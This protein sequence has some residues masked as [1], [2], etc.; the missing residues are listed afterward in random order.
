[1]E[2]LMYRSS[3]IVPV[4]CHLFCTEPAAQSTGN[5]SMEPDTETTGDLTILRDKTSDRLAVDQDQPSENTLVTVIRVLYTCF[6]VLSLILL[7]SPRTQVINGVSLDATVNIT[8]VGNPYTVNPVERDVP[9]Q[10]PSNSRRTKRSAARHALGVRRAAAAVR[11]GGSR[12][13]VLAVP[14]LF[15]RPMNTQRVVSPLLVLGI[16][17]CHPF[18]VEFPDDAQWVR[19]IQQPAVMDAA[20]TASRVGNGRDVA[21]K[22]LAGLKAFAVSLAE[23]VRPESTEHATTGGLASGLAVGGSNGV[24]EKS[25]NETVQRGAE[26][27]A[28]VPRG[29]CPF[30]VKIFNAETAGFAGIIIHNKAT[31]E[32]ADVPVRMSPNKLGAEVTD[33]RAMFVTQRDGN[34][35]LAEAIAVATQSFEKMSFFDTPPIP[36]AAGGGVIGA[37]LLISLA[38]D[39]W[40]LDGW[41]SGGNGGFRIK[42]LVFNALSFLAN[43][44]FLVGVFVLFGGACTAAFLFVMMVRNYFV[45][46]RMFVLVLAPHISLGILWPSRSSGQHASNASEEGAADEEENILEQIVLPLKII[47]AGDLKD[48]DESDY[49]QH[50]SAEVS[51]LVS[52]TR[53]SATTKQLT[54][55][56]ARRSTAA[57]GTRMCC[58]I[59]IDEFVVGSK[60]R[61]LPCHHQFHTDW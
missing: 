19:G 1:M 7:T 58:A 14:A 57:G 2:F 20:P 45:H 17:A 34:M 39:C 43:L 46:G 55:V 61:E 33:I 49:F 47:E 27:Y 31:R 36:G 5:S 11:I 32:S 30:D 24:P 38:P 51:P 28:L 9:A 52:E 54:Q 16:D 3:A 37:P 21:E 48:D 56:G 26:W 6:I 23:L 44:L 59:C 18:S 8:V 35:L 12:N 15:G 40:P 53:M 50:E 13:T 29:N 25:D 4:S 22:L 60:V 41:G 42:R 10:H